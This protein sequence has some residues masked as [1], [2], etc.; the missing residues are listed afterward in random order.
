MS[1]GRKV[2]EHNDPL[3]DEAESPSAPQRPVSSPGT[4]RVP[5]NPGMP[6]TVTNPGMRAL[7]AA[8]SGPV[9]KKP[10][11]PVGKRLSS[12]ASN[13]FLNALAMAKELVQDFRGSDRFLKAKA[14]IIGGW[15]FISLVSIIIACPSRGVQT[16]ALG[17]RV[18]VLPNADRPQAAPSLTVSNT[19]ED[20]WEDVV[21]TVNGKYK[22]IVDKIDA[23]AIFTLTPKSLLSPGGPMPSD[24]RFLNAEMRTKN[25]KAELVK[26]GQ[27]LTE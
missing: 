24:Q 26:N 21:F 22:A 11:G 4:P 27:P 25:G 16:A 1:D 17:A 3:A 2:P 8:R 18:T 14:G 13:Q 10:E 12:E 5:S 9:A 7:S 15:I 20:P 6:R 19:D 23:G